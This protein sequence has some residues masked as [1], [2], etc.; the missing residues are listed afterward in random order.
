MNKELKEL[1]YLKNKKQLF[2]NLYIAINNMMAELGAEGEMNARHPLV[3][4][5]MDE[6]YELDNGEYDVNRLFK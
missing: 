2:I 6:L 4:A 5:V 3:E 1:Q